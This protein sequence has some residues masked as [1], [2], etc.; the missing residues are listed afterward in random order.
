MVLEWQILEVEN[1]AYVGILHKQCEARLA[2]WGPLQGLKGGCQIRTQM[3]SQIYEHRSAR[4][5]QMYDKQG[6][7]CINSESWD[8]G[9]LFARY[10]TPAERYDQETQLTQE[11][12]EIDV[13]TA[14][15]VAKLDAEF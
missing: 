10:L 3:G 15:Y 6:L 8:F 4:E 13:K 9:L 7:C 5:F 14:G 12:I 2:I 11:C 1:A